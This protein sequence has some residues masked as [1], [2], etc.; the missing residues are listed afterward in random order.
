VLLDEL[1]F[2]TAKA[3]DAKILSI[4]LCILGVVMYLNTADKSG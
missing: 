3:K 2:F 1:G 4:F